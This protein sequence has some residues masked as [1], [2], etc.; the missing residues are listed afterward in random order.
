MGA[1]D[2][3]SKPFHLQELAARIYALIRRKSFENH[4]IISQKELEVNLLAK[5]VK[6]NQQLVT[7]TKKEL[8][9]LLY[10]VAN[11]NRVIPK[12]AIAEHLSGDLADILDNYDFIYAHIKNLKKKLTDA[13]MNN[14]LKTL[15]GTGYK[16]TDE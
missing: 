12:S 7:L 10:F 8:D 13:G 15:Y 9:L 14:Y 16:W 3:L 2:Y 4:N 1:D 11:K 6:V 5:T